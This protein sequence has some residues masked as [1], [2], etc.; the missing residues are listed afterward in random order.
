[1]NIE[2]AHNVNGTLI[3]NADDVYSL[4]CS[5]GDEIDGHAD[6][7]KIDDRYHTSKHFLQKKI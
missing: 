2:V 4:T 6:A 5:F 7:R 3:Q 1:M